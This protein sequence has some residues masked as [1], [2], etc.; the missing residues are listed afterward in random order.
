MTRILKLIS[1][2]IDK[3]IKYFL[4]IFLYMKMENNYYQEHKKR[5]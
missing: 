4:Y 2:H 1:K 3:L 5:I